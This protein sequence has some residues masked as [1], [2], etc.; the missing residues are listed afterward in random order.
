MLASLFP[1]NKKAKATK[2]TDAAELKRLFDRFREA[3]EDLD[4]DAMEE[5]CE[6]ITSFAFEG[7][8]KELAGFLEEATNNIDVETCIQILDTWEPMIEERE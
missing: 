1:E 4:S 2:K 6:A 3:A 5:V 8:Q 7:K